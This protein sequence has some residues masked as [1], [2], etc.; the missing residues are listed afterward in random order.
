M[1]VYGSFIKPQLSARKSPFLTY[2]DYGE[3][4]EGYWDYNHMVL[5]FEDV[6]DCLKVLQHPNNHF[7]FLFDHSSGHAKQRPDG[8]NASRMNKSF[9]GKS[10][11]M[12]PT[13]IVGDS[14]FLGPYPCILEPG[15]TQR[16]TFTKTDVG[17]FWMTPMSAFAIV[18]T[19]IL[20]AIQQQRPF[21]ETNLSQSLSYMAKE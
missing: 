3:N 2:F 1:V 11:P 21:R 13:V 18:L 7:V 9:G 20:I 17:P 19:K 8:L 6:V 12:H 15:H 14:G 5:Q 4:K 16:L 10:P